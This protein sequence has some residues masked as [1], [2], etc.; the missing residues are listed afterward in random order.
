MKLWE[1]KWF[2]KFI[3]CCRKWKWFDEKIYG[4]SE[5]LEDF[6]RNP[7]EVLRDTTFPFVIKNVDAYSILNLRI[8]YKH[9]TDKS[10]RNCWLIPMGEHK[11]VWK[12]NN[13]TLVDVRVFNPFWTKFCNAVFFAQ[14]AVSLKYYIPIPYVSL[15]IRWSKVNYFQAG[16]G[17][18]P[19][20]GDAVLCAKFRFV[21]QQTSS[22]NRW[23]PS[24]VTGFWEGTI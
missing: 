10:P 2:Q 17:W 7:A 6:V 16:L 19:E 18:G 14:L 9:F 4:K 13:W 3:A 20:R 12:K 22:E 8:G 24:D 1:Y 11:L 5:N 23:N 15:C 21:N